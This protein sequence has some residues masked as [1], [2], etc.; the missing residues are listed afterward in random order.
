MYTYCDSDTYVYIYG[1]LAIPPKG[2]EVDDAD[3]GTVG[4]GIKY[5]GRLTP[6]VEGTSYE[7]A[8]VV[9][10]AVVVGVTI[11]GMLSEA[12]AVAIW[13]IGNVLKVLFM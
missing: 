11:G 4:V 6:E 12:F 3:T 8:A 2:I 7:A 10:T 5:L 13:S 1:G 9:P